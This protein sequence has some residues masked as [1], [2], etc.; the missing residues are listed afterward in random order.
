MQREEMIARDSVHRVLAAVF[1]GE[2]AVHEAYSKFDLGVLSFS[3]REELDAYIAEEIAQ[4][5]T[6]VHLVLHYPDTKGSIRKKRI[7]LRPEACNG[8]TLRYS[9]EGWGLIQFQLDYKASPKVKCRF[10]VNT[11]KRANAWAQTIPRLGDPVLWDW[12]AVEKHARRLIRV[13]RKCADLGSSGSP[14]A[15]AELKP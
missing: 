6:Y 15:A 5:R 14:S 1:E 2:P 3:K 11:E 10:A 12:T 13:L 4:G 8:A 7:D 9:M